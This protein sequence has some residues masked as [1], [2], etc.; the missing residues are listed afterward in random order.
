MCEWSSIQQS[1]PSPKSS[2]GPSFH[3]ASPD[4]NDSMLKLSIPHLSCWWFHVLVCWLNDW[5]WW[6]SCADWNGF[7]GFH[8][9]EYWRC[10]FYNPVVLPNAFPAAFSTPTTCL[11]ALVFVKSGVQV[12]SGFWGLSFLCQENLQVAVHQV[13]CLWVDEFVD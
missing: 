9:S 8:C 13:H 12:R 3:R 7:H 11:W 6:M 2:L 10:L 4:S 5:S 1:L